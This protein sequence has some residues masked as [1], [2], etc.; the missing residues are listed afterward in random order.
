MR[1]STESR[2]DGKR[3]YG[4][5]KPRTLFNLFDSEGVVDVSPCPRSS[6]LSSL[7]Y[8]VQDRGETR[9]RGLLLSPASTVKDK[10]GQGTMHGAKE[11]LKDMASATKE[12]AKEYSGKAEGKAEAATARTPEEREAADERAKAREK[13]AKAEYHE[14]NAEHQEESA[15]HRGG[16]G[17]VPLTSQHHHRPVGADPTY[18]GIGTGRPA[19]E[20]YL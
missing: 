10:L 1:S 7:P 12:K 9:C 2:E 8:E 19:G 17:R 11:K 15:A 4:E 20:K 14:E 18:P 3:N 6:E 16:T 13:A 5:G